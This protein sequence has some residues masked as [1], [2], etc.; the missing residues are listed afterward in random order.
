MYYHIM[1]VLIIMSKGSRLGK[2]FCKLYA[3]VMRVINYSQIA[4]SVQ[5]NL[6]LLSLSTCDE[7][8]T[9]SG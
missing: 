1:F 7:V 5:I 2:V 4:M 6:V 8:L 3:Q 9:T